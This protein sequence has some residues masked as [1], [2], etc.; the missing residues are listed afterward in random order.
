MTTGSPDAEE[1]KDRPKTRHIDVML[2]QRVRLVRDARPVSRQDMA[3]YLGVS[4]A[5]VQRY[6][7]G[8]QRIAAARLWQI[9]RRLDVKLAHLFAGLPHNVAVDA[10]LAEEEAPIFDREDG[11]AEMLVVLAK[12]VGKLPT[13]RLEIAIPVVK[14][15]KPKRS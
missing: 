6:E 8:S 5:T 7:N 12:A 2:G 1:A 10:G 11:R 4:L 13:D 15:L 3:D 9:C 14:A